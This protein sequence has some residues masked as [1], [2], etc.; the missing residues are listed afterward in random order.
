MAHIEKLSENTYRIVVSVGYNA[1]GKKLRKYRTVTLPDGMTER[2]R[3]KELKRQE[4]LF[5][6]EVKTGAY[7]DGAN[8]TFA[9][10]TQKWLTDY[11][12]KQL[13]PGT[14]VPYKM[15]LEKRIL[16][17]IG[18][19]K[20]ARLQPHHLV[21]FYNNLSEEGLR[22]DSLYTPTVALVRLLETQS[23]P[24]I[25]KMSGLT[26]KTAQRIKKGNSTTREA[27]EKICVALGGD[28]KKLF[29]YDRDKKLSAKTIRNHHGIISSILSTAV[30][31]NIINSNP[32]KRVDLGKMA[33]YKP[34]YY[35]D[36]QIASMF[37]ALEGEP[38][39]YKVMLYLTVETGLRTG[40]VTGLHW[41]DIDLDKGVV[42]ISKQR[43]YVTGYGTFEK[44]PK[45]ESGFRTITLSGKVTTM[46][47]QY[48]N[49]QIEELLS[50]G[51]AWKADNLVFV[52]EDGTPIHPHNP[53]KWFT[54]FLER[55][56]LPKITYHQLRH[57]NTSLLMSMGV[58]LATLSGRLGHGDKNIT[59]NTYSHMIKS[60]EAQVANS[61]DVF[62]SQLVNK[63]VKNWS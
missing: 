2:Q 45:T 35:D 27:A 41:T 40:E 37:A 30:K 61:M 15:R 32:A 3:E 49:Q 51:E 52:H 28:I 44:G 6:Q 10:F 9:A 24:D 21:E 56:G 16:P 26:F 23:T 63:E 8:I 13:A 57:S 12:E 54:K 48:R 47:R 1:Q 17:A 19:I 59:L 42:T 25:I 60:K 50:L 11:A 18:H 20:L 62:Y 43:Q 29:I 31:W 53:Y 7:L 55:H 58:D 36:E 33:K 38:L 4:V 22:L 39:R 5:E 34:A 46:L 14:L